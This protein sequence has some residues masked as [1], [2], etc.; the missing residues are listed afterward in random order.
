MP[1]RVKNGVSTLGFKLRVELVACRFACK[2]RPTSPL[3]VVGLRI[4]RVPEH[5]HRVAN[6]L[7]DRPAFGEKRL[8]Q[9]GEIARSLVHESVGVGGLGDRRKIPDVGENDG[10][11]LPY[12]AKFSGYRIVYDSAGRSP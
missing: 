2:D 7:V 1:N 11:L 12:S 5:H 4:G 10:D 9:R 6:E 3:D 8:R